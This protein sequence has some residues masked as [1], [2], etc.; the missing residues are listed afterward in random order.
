[1][2]YG[3]KLNWCLLTRC[4]TEGKCD[5]ACAH[6]EGAGV[7]GLHVHTVPSRFPGHLQYKDVL[8]A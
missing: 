3:S 8:P 5:T 6:Q 2:V 4:E 1:M 7:T